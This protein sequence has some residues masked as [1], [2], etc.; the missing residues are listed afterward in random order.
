MM[1][2]GSSFILVAVSVLLAQPLAADCRML[3][4]GQCSF[5]ANLHEIRE[6][7]SEIRNAIVSKTC[8]FLN[9]LLRFYVENVFKHYTP[10]SDL[11]KRKTSS[12]A[13]SFL[14]VKRDLRQC[15]SNKT[16][17]CFEREIPSSWEKMFDKPMELL[18]PLIESG[19]IQC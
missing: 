15:V 5:V 12:L 3:H 13:N 1:T 14:S 4:V 19:E 16:Y 6:Y 17:L 2:F 18:V 11:I 7:F 8:C 10:T 9:H